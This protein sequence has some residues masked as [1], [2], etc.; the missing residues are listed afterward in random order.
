MPDML[1]GE[2]WHG[3]V[4]EVWYGEVREVWHGGARE[5]G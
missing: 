3:E 1:C 4:R 5:G 2:V